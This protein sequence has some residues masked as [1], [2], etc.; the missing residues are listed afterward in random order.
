[1]IM[2]DLMFIAEIGSNWFGK[3]EVGKYLQERAKAAGATAVKYQ[4]WK[5]DELYTDPK[6]KYFDFV[7][8]AELSYEAAKE[9]KE[10]ADSIDIGWFASVHTKE[11]IDFL[12]SIDAPYIKIK[13]SQNEDMD[14]LEYADSFDLDVILSQEYE[15]DAIYLREKI[16][17][18][19]PKYPSEFIDL[20]FGELSKEWYDG[21]SDHTKGIEA[22]LVAAAYPNIRI[23]ERHFT[24]FLGSEFNLNESGTPD[25]SVSL[26]PTE[27][28]KMCK[29]IR[30]IKGE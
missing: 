4:L 10:Y 3:V 23:F 14:L 2:N 30:H 25:Y 24:A 22:S 18:T 5:A 6:W 7:R 20:D 27:F 12:V 1:M 8:K 26:Y 28:E 13:C 15:R 9:L 11:D 29:K 19:T 17:Y 16:L 21:F